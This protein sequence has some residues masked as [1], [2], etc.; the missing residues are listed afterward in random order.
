MVLYN[1]SQRQRGLFWQ[2]RSTLI[3]LNDSM[4]LM[5]QRLNE[6]IMFWLIAWYNEGR[7]FFIWARTKA[8][9]PFSC[10]R[11]WSRSRRVGDESSASMQDEFVE[12]RCNTQR[13]SE[14]NDAIFR[15]QELPAA[16]WLCVCVWLNADDSQCV[17]MPKSRCES[18]G[19]YW[20]G[21]SFRRLE[22]RWW[23]WWFVLKLFVTPWARG[24]GND[25][26]WLGQN[27]E[28]YQW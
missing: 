20:S 26:R 21:W 1:T 9:R 6:W 23:R 22:W 4:T 3:V 24:G 16:P 2:G 5:V 12:C 14:W 28:R 27:N 7:E 11:G 10:S 15:S 13:S 17:I 25:G 19:N 8:I 18:M